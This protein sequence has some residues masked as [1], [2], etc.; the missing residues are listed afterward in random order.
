MTV[1]VTIGTSVASW[2]PKT[3]ETKKHKFYVN[4][5]FWWKYI[6]E[7]AMGNEQWPWPV[8]SLRSYVLKQIIIVDCILQ[9]F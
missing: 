9:I 6:D 2:A 1:N 8:C 3:D 7:E 4:L 5:Y